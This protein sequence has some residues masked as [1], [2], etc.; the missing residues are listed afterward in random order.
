M[1]NT[2][3]SFPRIE[4]CKKNNIFCGIKTA[5]ICQNGSLHRKTLQLAKNIARRFK[6]HLTNKK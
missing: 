2:K 4:L 6:R 3:F 5:M 1:E